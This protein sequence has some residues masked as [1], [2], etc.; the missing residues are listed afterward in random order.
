MNK[1]LRVNYPLYIGFVLVSLL[2]FL[3]IF[4]PMLAPHTLTETLE[5]HYENGNIFAP[6]L[7]P[8]KSSSYPL[9]T[10]RWGYDM[11]TMVLNGIRY[12]VFISVIVTLIKMIF[13]SVIGIYVGTWKKTPGW[14]ESIE[15][16]W[17]YVPLFLVLFFFLKQINFEENVDSNSLIGYFIIV[18]SMI[19]MPSIISSVRKKSHEISKSVFIEAG[20]AL[21]AN[22]HR[23]IWKHIFPQMKESL[24]VMFILEIVYVITIM[25]QLALM[26][27]FIGGTLVRRDPTYFLSITKELSGLV[28]QARGNIYGSFHVLYVPL[29][30]LLITTLSFNLLANGL[31][32]RYQSNYQR[33]PW[34]KTGFEPKLISKRKVYVK[35]KYWWVPTGERLVIVLV[36]MIFFIAGCFAYISKDND[37]GV[38]NDNQAK[39]DLSIKMNKDGEFHSNTKI[40]VTNRSDKKW[41][42]LVFYFIP[43]SFTKGHSFKSI[44]N[45]SKVDIEKISIDGTKAKYTLE[46]DTLRVK[47][48]SLMGKWDRVNVS[49]SYR[50][51]LPDNGSRLSKVDNQYYL[52]QWY[53]ML[54]T[55]QNG[56]WNK[57]DYQEGLETYHTDFSN[58]RVEFEIPKGYSFISSADKDPKWKENVG[59]VQIK[60]IRDF[61]IA[62]TKDMKMYTTSSKGVEIRLFTKTNHNKDPEK[63]LKLAK[64]ALDF[65]QE[66]IGEYPHKQLDIVLDEG[67]DMEYAGIVTVN[68]YQDNDRFYKIAIVHEIAHQYFYGV[69]ANDSYHEAWLD[70][71]ITEFATNM[72]FYLGEGQGYNQAQAFSNERMERIAEQGLGRQ[73][74]NVP[75]SEIKDNGYIYGQPALQMFSLIKDKY[76]VRDEDFQKVLMDYLSDYYHHFQYKE[77]NTSEFIRFTKDYFQVPTGYFNEWLDTSELNY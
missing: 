5:T 4:G 9:G 24:L 39:Y 53:P 48:A 32:N 64:K 50:L 66:N 23:I 74:S 41:N 25:G 19:S 44:K 70:E 36:V 1:L 47:L 52:A 29:T 72:Y 11:L 14:I 76:R 55:F 15:H 26:N 17:S 13:G 18:T 28:G 63:T 59:K 71:G 68:P 20:R 73:Y 3:S 34:I 49:I 42:E 43:N 37:I 22:R 12:T 58:Y 35:Q 60:K 67:L 10:D 21:G 61:F 77:V 56:K 54:A 45:F 62:I 27:I 65:Y 31:K 40:S 57:E 75:L 33:T 38:E 51:T 16:A 6:P 30:V 46:N 2:I 7:D 8:F 69:V